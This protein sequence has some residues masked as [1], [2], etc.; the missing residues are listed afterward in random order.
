MMDLKVI[1]NGIGLYYKDRLYWVRRSGWKLYHGIDWRC[2]CTDKVC[3]APCL[4][5]G[6]GL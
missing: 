3:F 5:C 1:P 4:D 2:N 6:A